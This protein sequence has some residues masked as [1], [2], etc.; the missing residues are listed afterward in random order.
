MVVE[1][2]NKYGVPYV[3][4]YNIHNPEVTSS[5]LVLAT[6][7]APTIVGAFF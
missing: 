7:K 6:I 3:S 4:S 2:L 1:G 5:N